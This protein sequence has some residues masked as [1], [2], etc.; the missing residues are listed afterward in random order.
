MTNN[1]TRDFALKW[2]DVD[3]GYVMAGSFEPGARDA[4]TPV[5]ATQIVIDIYQDAAGNFIAGTGERLPS[6]IDNRSLTAGMA[7]R[8]TAAR[9]TKKH[10]AGRRPRNSVKQ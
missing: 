8:Q 1:N 10:I 5:K 6:N 3:D 4:E 7:F 2:A 9:R